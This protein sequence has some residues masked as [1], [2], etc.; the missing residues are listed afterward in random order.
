MLSHIAP[1]VFEHTSLH[2]LQHKLTALLR[3]RILFFFISCGV[4]C[5]LSKRVL[6]LLG[7]PFEVAKLGVRSLFSVVFYIPRQKRK[8]ARKETK[9]ERKAEVT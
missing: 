6:S 1:A 4:S 3:V 8:E 2:D 9:C 7:I 5:S